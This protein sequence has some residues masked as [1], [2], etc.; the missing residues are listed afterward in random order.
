MTLY[1]FVSTVKYAKEYWV[2]ATHKITN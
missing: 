2:S 1:G